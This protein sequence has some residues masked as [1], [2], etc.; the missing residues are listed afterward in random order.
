LRVVCCQGS[1]VVGAVVA[2]VAVTAVDEDEE[3]GEEA[4]EVGVDVG[5]GAVALDV[6][7][8]TV[9]DDPRVERGGLAAITPVR[10]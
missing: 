4:S 9:V 1:A 2:E 8:I 5:S 6:V 10:G 3:D 7:A